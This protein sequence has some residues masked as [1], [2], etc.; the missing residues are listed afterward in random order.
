MGLM[1]KFKNLFTEEVEEVKPIKKEV[2]HVEIKAPKKEPEEMP[3]KEENTISDSTTI[4]KRK[5][6]FSSLF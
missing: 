6:R 4:K 1:D 2:R 5:I 3:K